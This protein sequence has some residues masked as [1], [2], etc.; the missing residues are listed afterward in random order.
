MRTPAWCAKRA[1][2]LGP[3]VAELVKVLL[4]SATWC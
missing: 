2:E 4:E 1:A 3:A